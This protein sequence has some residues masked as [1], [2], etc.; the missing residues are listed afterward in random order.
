MH[1]N[2]T[3][4]PAITGAMETQTQGPA[5]APARP[6]PPPLPPQPPG[7]PPQQAAV[8]LSATLVDTRTASIEFPVTIYLDRQGVARMIY[9]LT[10]LLAQMQ[11]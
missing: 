11:D 8:A 10:G 3:Q 7:D 5:T 9:Q 4:P 2:T 6:A 1:N